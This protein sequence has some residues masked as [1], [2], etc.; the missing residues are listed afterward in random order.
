[1][2]AGFESELRQLL[3]RAAAE[4][5]STTTLCRELTRRDFRP[6][7]PRRRLVSVALPIAAGMIAA[8]VLMLAV[9]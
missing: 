3:R 9:R 5:G 6:R 4:A 2:S 1:M 8:A 7:R